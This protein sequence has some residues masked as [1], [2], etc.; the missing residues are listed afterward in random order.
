MRLVRDHPIVSALA[1]GC[2]LALALRVG[3]GVVMAASWLAV[4]RYLPNLPEPSVYGQLSMPTSG[5]GRLLLSV[6]LRWDAIHQLNLAIHSYSIA[7]PGDSVFFPLYAGLTRLVALFLGGKYLEA[8]LLVSTLSAAAAF[9][10][11]ILLGERL[12]GPGSGRWAAISLAVFPTAVFLMAPFTESLFIA[13]TLGALVSA[14]RSRWLLAAACALLA[15]L[16]R[17]PGLMLSVPL[18]IIG[19]YQWI[20]SARPRRLWHGT[21][22]IAASAAPLVGGLSFLAWRSQAGFPPMTETLRLYT[23]TAFV[24][25]L[26]GLVAGFD[27]WLHVRDLPTTLDLL[28]AIFILALATLMALRPRWRQPELLAYM[29]VMAVLLLGRKT[30]GAPSLK[31]LARYVLGL[32]PAF[33]VVGDWLASARPL[34]RFLVVTAS[35]SALIALSALY[36]LW[37]FLG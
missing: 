21:S 17:G 7:V 35:S 24:D 33:A 31:S 19:Y 28:A 12:F 30:E 23:G 16:T 29:L 11:L 14:Y 34:T 37:F 27:Q 6:W 20:S 3:L 13:L 22:L 8:G 1:Y 25:P 26:T 9:A 4:E 10:L 32:F 15:S 36:T 2:G 5:L 18:A